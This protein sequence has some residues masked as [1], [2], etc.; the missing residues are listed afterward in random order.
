MIRPSNI[1]IEA[2]TADFHMDGK[3]AYKLSVDLNSLAYMNSD[4]GILVPGT[5]LT[6]G[7]DAGADEVNSVSTTF[8]NEP[9]HLNEL[10][11]ALAQAKTE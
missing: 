1:N 6:E 9:N 7:V 5:L 8:P 4:V 2:H 3:D 11:A 10:F